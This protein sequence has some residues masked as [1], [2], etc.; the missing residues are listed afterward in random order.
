MAGLIRPEPGAA[1]LSA[2]RVS[3]VATDQ[4]R[5]HN[6]SAILTLLHHGGS[7]ARSALTA[8]TGLNRSTVGALVAELNE[9]GLAYET[10]PDPTNQVGRPSPTVNPDERNVAIAINP[11]VDA[12]TLGVVALGGRV[13]RTIRHETDHVPTAQEAVEI[14]AE[15][16]T[17]IE[18]EYTVDGP[19][20]GIGVA[21]PG[22]VRAEDG[23]V[24][25]APHLE[26]VD[27]PVGTML[28]EATG[29]DVAVG[30]DASLA[31][32]VEHIYGAGR[33]LRDMVYFN[34]SPSGIGG[35]VIAN[36]ALLEG[37]SG[38]A[39]ELGHTRSGGTDRTLE[40]RVLRAE[41]L[42][43]LGR[44][45]AT[46]DE[47]ETLVLA[48]NGRKVANV[49]RSQLEFLGTAIGDAVNILNPQR[50]VLGGFLATLLRWVFL[51]LGAVAAL[52][53]LGVETSS[54][55]AL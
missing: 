34:G 29:Y 25:L 45:T 42:A 35:G 33:G 7:Q 2:P 12:I 11:E 48:D 49:V 22:L 1:A 54:F 20:V 32:L 10:D 14:C 3:G 47:L 52:A 50:V 28:A 27:E 55:L 5:R 37:A 43:A 21:V 18:A 38:Y 23:L 19:I 9:R 36:G 39:G 4:L 44:T 24:R 17:S 31:A 15:M 51:G 16:I 41:L 40:S 13:V 6:L 30:N 46:P 53:R 26:W 8:R